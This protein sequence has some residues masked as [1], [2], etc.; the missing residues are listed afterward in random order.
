MGGWDGGS[1]DI[2]S[3]R[4]REGA[5]VAS[6]LGSFLLSAKS[7]ETITPVIGGGTI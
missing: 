3:W 4:G 1:L 6:F 7:R 5:V 2:G